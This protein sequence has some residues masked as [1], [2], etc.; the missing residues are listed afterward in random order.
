[1]HEEKPKIVVTN[2]ELQKLE[3]ASVVEHMQRAKAVPL[4]REIGEAKSSG[5]DSVITV[6]TLA[7]A[8]F[9]GGFVAWLL[10]QITPEMSTTEMAN[11]TFTFQLTLAVAAILI[12]GDGILSR[13]VAKLGMNALLGIPVAIGS[14]LILGYLASIL[15]STL[16]ENT[17]NALLDDGLDPVFDLE[18]FIEAFNSR[19]HLNR[20]TA[21]SLVGLAAGLSV[22]APTKSA[23]R[24]GITGAGGLVG[25]FIG[26]FLFDFIPGEES[27]QFLGLAITGL[28][29]GLTASLLEQA[30][31]SSWIEIVRGGMAG[32]QFIVYQNSVTIGSSP[33]ANITLIKDP[34]ILPVAGTIKRMGSTYHLIAADPAYPIQVDGVMGAK[35]DL[36]E[37]SSIVLGSTEINFRTKAKAVSQG[38][39]IRG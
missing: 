36:R 25:G 8:G 37:G 11:L 38:Q 7:G 31:K 30:V 29:I 17:W 28:S 26:G 23:K 18:G 12:I 5:R 13:S 32:K 24:V 21:W 39:V 16:V 14:A 3:V 19:N 9:L 20:G 6:G 35:H 1:M 22:G 10:V 27:A 33:S 15:Y 4:V 34:A 2:E